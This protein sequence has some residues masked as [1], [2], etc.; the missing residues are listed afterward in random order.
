MTDPI[1]RPYVIAIGQLALA[2]NDLH[3]SLALLFIE[4]LAQGRGYPATD[5][6]N[7]VNFDRPKRLLLKAVLRTAEHNHP[8]KRPRMA[9]DITWLLG[10]IDK[11]EDSRNDAI[12]SPLTFYDS[13]NELEIGKVR[14]SVSF[15]NRR[16][17]RLVDKDLLSEFRWCRD[18]SLTLRNFTDDIWI[19]LAARDAWPGRPALPNRGQRKTPRSRQRPAPPK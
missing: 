16:A 5:I 4:L 9:Q 13:A 14:P 7:A 15:E 3:E 6:W 17:L 11:V 2:W 19:S 1:Y 18:M 10:Q 8:T 12:H